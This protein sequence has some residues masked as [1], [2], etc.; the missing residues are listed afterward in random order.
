MKKILFLFV[1]AFSLFSFIG[2]K[3]YVK[4][5]VAQETTFVISTNFP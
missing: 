5:I 2:D 1:L 3:D 4:P